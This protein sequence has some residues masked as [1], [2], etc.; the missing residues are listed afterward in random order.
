MEKRPDVWGI[1][2]CE[3]CPIYSTVEVLRVDLRSLHSHSRILLLP[4]HIL[5][6]V[7]VVVYCPENRLRWWAP[8]VRGRA[9]AWLSEACPRLISYPT[10]RERA[11]PSFAAWLSVPLFALRKPRATRRISYRVKQPVIKLDKLFTQNRKPIKARE[12]EKIPDA[13]DNIHHSIG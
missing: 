4:T 5:R 12:G 11:R 13:K 1:G 8:A 2:Q 3:A 6:W 9:E 10:R 7:R